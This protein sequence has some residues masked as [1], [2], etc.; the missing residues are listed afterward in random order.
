L[1]YIIVFIFIYK[2]TIFVKMDKKTISQSILDQIQ[3][4]ILPSDVTINTMTVICHMDMIFNVSNIAKYI[5]LSLDGIIKISHG[6][7]GDILTNRII[8]HKKKFKKIKKNK[9]VFFNQVSLSVVIPSKKE[10]PVNLKIFSNG[11]MQMTGCKHIDNAIEAIERTFVELRKIKAIV[12]PK[13]MC[14]VEKPFCSKPED[15]IMS[16]VIAMEVAM[17]V[18]KFTYPININRAKLYEL[19]LKDN[20]EAKYDPELHA[21]VDLKFVS[22]DKKISVFI[23]EKGSIVITG[24]KTCKHILEA[25][26]FVNEYLL[27]HHKI[28]SKK[29]I[30]QDDIEKF[31]NQR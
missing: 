4:T 16:K 25:Y 11:S 18:S 13:K 23:F 22:G 28:I 15:L 24:A 21:S 30:K 6:R 17:I 14:L 10:R 9:K 27:T 3:I 12:D 26:N 19:F 20:L 1:Y 29:N 31:I 8:V 2:L 5:D 7:S